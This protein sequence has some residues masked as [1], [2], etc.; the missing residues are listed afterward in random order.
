MVGAAS[1][2]C[3]TLEETDVS[4]VRLLARPMLSAVF[5]AGGAEQLLHPERMAGNAHGVAEAI[6]EVVEPVRKA[7]DVQLVQLNGAV[8]VLGGVLLALGKLPRLAALL[9]AGSLVP[10]TLAEHRFWEIND[11]QAREADKLHFLKNVSMLGGLLIATMDL[12]G[13]PGL[14]WRA[15]HTV[16]RAKTTVDH[17]GEVARL[18]AGHTVDHAKVAAEHAAEIGRLRAELAKK[19]F[20]PDPVDHLKMRAELTKQRLTPDVTDLKALVDKVRDH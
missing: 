13:R 17:V 16:D 10:T 1:A 4:P 20:S 14:A 8:Q 18:R 7:S 5:V 6:G 2:S 3:P 15:G 11:P 9:L 12:E 19:V